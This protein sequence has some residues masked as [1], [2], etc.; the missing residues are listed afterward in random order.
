MVE[1]EQFVERGILRLSNLDVY[2]ILRY[3]YVYELIPT[4]R[5]LSIPFGTR[6][7]NPLHRTDACALKLSKK[8]E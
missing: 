7:T 2:T 5:N 8:N 6:V 4:R 3:D 1:I